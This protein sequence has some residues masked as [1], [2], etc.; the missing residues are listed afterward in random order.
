MAAHSIEQ[1]ECATVKIVTNNYMRPALEQLEH[2]RHCR[3]AGGKRKSSGAAFQIGN[4]F[5]VSEPGRINRARVIIALVLPG[6]FLNVRRCCINRRHYRACGRIGFLPRVNRARSEFVLL[7]HWSKLARESRA[8]KRNS[9]I[10]PDRS[11]GHL[12]P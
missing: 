4:A 1:S 8:R 3:Q 12:C 7:F 9:G 2:S 10:L 5:F 6:A 11:S